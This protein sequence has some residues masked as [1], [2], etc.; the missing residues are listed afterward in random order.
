MNTCVDKGNSNHKSACLLLDA[1]GMTGRHH[2]LIQHH[3]GLL[4]QGCSLSTQY[5][6]TF[7]NTSRLGMLFQ[8]TCSAYAFI[9]H[10]FSDTFHIQLSPWPA[11]KDMDSTM[12]IHLTSR[13]HNIS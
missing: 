1:G 10:T 8:L 3:Q 7:C 6:C 12:V 4:T 9:K 13:R 5:N 11:S 2:T